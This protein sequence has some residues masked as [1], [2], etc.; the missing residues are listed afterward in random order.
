[1]RNLLALAAAAV[2][3]FVVVGWYL[4]W[5]KFQSTPEPDGHRQVTI[6]LNSKKIGEDLKKGEA[7]LHGVLDK[8]QK[9]PTAPPPVTA[10]GLPVP[11]EVLKEEA[12]GTW[13]LN[14]NTQQWQHDG[15][16]PPNPTT[17]TGGLPVPPPY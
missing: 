4:G 17:S 1:M 3:T 8:G 7:K 9:P 5:Y 10:Q 12:N 6:D 16:T 2:L 15:P 11:P 13:V 14:P